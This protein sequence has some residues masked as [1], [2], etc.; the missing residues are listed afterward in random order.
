M[1]RCRP[2]HRFDTDQKRALTVDPHQ[3]YRVEIRQ[4]ACQRIGQQAALPKGHRSMVDKLPTTALGRELQLW[5][6]NLLVLAIVFQLVA[7]AIASPGNAATSA[8]CTANGVAFQPGPSHEHAW[9]CIHWAPNAC[10]ALVRPH[11]AAAWS[12]ALAHK[13]D[14]RPSATLGFST[15]RLR[16]RQTGPPSPA[17]GITTRSDP[18]AL[19]QGPG[20]PG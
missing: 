18:R 3:C 7:P 14:Q 1:L 9:P 16:P 10:C 8:I 17:W 2:I 6:G 11:H 12:P 15:E 13:A 20:S 19:P 5:R 4:D